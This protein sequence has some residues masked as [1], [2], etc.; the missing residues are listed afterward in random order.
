MAKATVTA[1]HYYIGID[2]GTTHS[3]LSYVSSG[4][5]DAI[6]TLSIPQINEDGT[7]TESTI[8][9]SFLYFPT[10]E[11]QLQNPEIGK[12]AQ[13]RGEETPSRV[14]SSAK[15]WICHEGMDQRQLN[16]P[17]GDDVAAE[18]KIAPQKALS[19]ILQKLKQ[20]WDAAYPKAPFKQQKVLVTVPASFD[21]AAK[22]LVLEAAA[23]ADYPDITLIEEPLAAFY[24]W[25]Q[26]AKDAWRTHLK[27]GDTVLVVDVGGG[28]T[29]FTLIEVEDRDGNLELNRAAV[30]SHLLLGG[31]N[32]DH[33][34]AHLAQQQFAEKGT[35]LSDWQYQS[36]VHACRKAKEQLFGE[37]PPASVDLTILGRGSK[38]IGG[39]LKTTIE[40]KQ[41]EESV[42]EG[43]FPLLSRDNLAQKNKR[44]GFAQVGLTYA[45]D[46]RITAQLATFLDGRALPSKVLFNGGTMKAAAFRKRV[47]ALLESWGS[48][49]VEELSGANYDFGVSIGAV[50]YALAREGQAI[51]VRSGASKSY[52]VAVEE[53]AP[54]VPGF[55]PKVKKICVVP[56]GM[57]EGSEATLESQEF[58][59]WLGEQV[60]FRFFSRSGEAHFG[61]YADATADSQLEELHPIET[62]LDKEGS[63]GKTVQVK[64]KSK[65]TELGFLELW[66]ESVDSKKWKLEFNLRT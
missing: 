63:E 30:G 35:S 55:A 40:L 43:F 65:V 34:L 19:L 51:R 26:Q 11:E 16:L 48:Q 50:C 56:C 18:H 17:L 44:S 61:D 33:L 37:K 14:V 5:S 49:Q 28:T 45:Q 31:D 24:A 29:D 59:L 13:K 42:L 52:Y 46:A 22:Q 3:S 41:A 38:L 10:A 21:P 15:S 1:S 54:A 7:L 53:A 23:A 57:E 60:T 58:S 8:L 47:I 66:C 2:L 39:S 27:V 62:I 12:L 32:I 36:L 25:L 64:L 4:E 9:P 20:T 6:H